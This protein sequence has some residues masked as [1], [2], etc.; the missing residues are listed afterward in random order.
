MAESWDGVNGGGD[1]G[2]GPVRLTGSSP[3]CC[4]GALQPSSP[5]PHGVALTLS[6]VT[7]LYLRGVSGK[8]D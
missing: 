3:A 8:A 7:G 2:A 5:T 6:L 4:R 1:T